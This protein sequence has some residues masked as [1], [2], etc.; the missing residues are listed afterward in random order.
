M[1][2]ER[3][4]RNRVQ[5]REQAQEREQRPSGHRP[6]R[7]N[8]R[9]H[10]GFHHHLRNPGTAPNHNPARGSSWTILHI[11]APRIAPPNSGGNKQSIVAG[12]WRRAASQSVFVRFSFAKIL[13][14]RVELLQNAQTVVSKAWRAREGCKSSLLRVM[15]VQSDP[16]F[17]K[18]PKESNGQPIETSRLEAESVGDPRQLQVEQ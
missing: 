8:H 7:G 2:A 16:I 5:C 15:T 18:D 6:R 13:P 1:P 4:Y 9:V 17:P 3:Q 11:P 12:R 14:T 10:T